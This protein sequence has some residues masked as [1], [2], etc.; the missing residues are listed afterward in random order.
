MR[1]RKRDRYNAT[2][3]LDREK[4][5]RF[6]YTEIETKGNH[7]KRYKTYSSKYKLK[8]VLEALKEEF[9]INVIASK[10]QTSSKN[11]YNWKKEFLSKADT[12]FSE[13]KLDKS[14][15]EKM[16][17]L[18]SENDELAKKLG[19]TLIERDWLAKKLNSS[20]FKIDKHQLVKSELNISKT[21]QCELL[22]INR[23]SL[24]YKPVAI[25]DRD[26]N[27]M[28]RID[29][30]YTDISP[31]YGYRNMYQQL[32]QEGH[33]IGINKVH[34]LMQIMGIQAIYPRKRNKA[35]TK[36]EQHKIYPYLL[37]KFANSKGQI[38]ATRANHIWSGD[39]TY[40]KIN[41]GFMYLAAIIDWYSKCII[42]W[43]LSNTA[44]TQLVSSVLQQAINKYGTPEIF[45]SDQGSQYTSHAYAKLLTTN[46][47]KISMNGKGRSI[48]NIAIERFFR[49][50]KYE[51]IYLND[52]TS[53]K[54]LKNGINKYIDFYNLNRFH[55]SLNY[56]KPKEVYLKKAA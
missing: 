9:P 42:A 19:K 6:P 50:I 43:K 56:K 5:K 25:S 14:H 49:T 41:G 24:Y 8:V 51:N 34:K 37:K 18:E 20:D 2:K 45:N 47:I 1:E 11:I 39:I 33:K 17:L 26:I 28:N 12:A 36:G 52:Y 13:S 48:D 16:A 3:K 15:K 27:A 29:E 35:H 54:Q 40:I 44:D 10:Y 21:R 53:V 31:C 4:R 32:K 55:S 23:S 46:N 38:I 30:V 7:V 22:H